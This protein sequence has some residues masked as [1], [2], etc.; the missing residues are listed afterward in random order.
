M[1]PSVPCQQICAWTAASACNTTEPEWISLTA[2]TL[3]V[4]FLCYFYLL[5]KVYLWSSWCILKK[6]ALLRENDLGGIKPPGLY[7]ERSSVFWFYL[8]PLFDRCVPTTA[9]QPRIVVGF[10]VW[11]LFCFLFFFVLYRSECICVYVYVKMSTYMCLFA[12]VFFVTTWEG[13]P[14]HAEYGYRIQKYISTVEFWSQCQQG[15]LVLLPTT[16]FLLSVVL[17][18]VTLFGSTNCFHISYFISIQEEVVFK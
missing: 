3:T 12:E 5:L 8:T 9:I 18:S 11:L 13:C 15:D 17:I 7:C 14:H 10:T 6:W 2:L 16:H 4:V 1:C